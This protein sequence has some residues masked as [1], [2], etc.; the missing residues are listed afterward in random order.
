MRCD[1]YQTVG[2]KDMLHACA[3]ESTKYQAEGENL[4]KAA[5][6]FAC[7]SQV[8]LRRSGGRNYESWSQRRPERDGRTLCLMAHDLLM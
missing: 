5:K 1:D 7:F 8:K 6:V 3:V 2:H 4:E